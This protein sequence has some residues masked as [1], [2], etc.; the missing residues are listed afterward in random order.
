MLHLPPLY[1]LKSLQ[2]PGDI[3]RLT[4]S[5]KPIIIIEGNVEGQ[6]EEEILLSEGRPAPEDYPAS[7]CPNRGVHTDGVTPGRGDLAG[8]AGG[9]VQPLVSR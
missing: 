9:A 2:G 6:T 7:K 1:R 8:D 5:T 4:Y 3:L